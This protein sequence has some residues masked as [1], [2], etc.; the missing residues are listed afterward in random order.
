MDEVIDGI[1]GDRWMRQHARSQVL[2]QVT[3][4]H[5]KRGFTV[6]EFNDLLNYWAWNTFDV[7]C[8][9]ATEGRSELIPRQEYE[10]VAF[11][12]IFL[13][14]SEFLKLAVLK[15]GWQGIIDRERA[16]LNELGTKA[17]SSAVGP[18]CTVACPI[19]GSVGLESLGL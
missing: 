4:E 17:R 3:L 6:D 19:F 7:L 9:R 18:W 10:F 15:V 8:L 13:R 14:N 16:A 2:N 1:A 12:R 5:F 11:N